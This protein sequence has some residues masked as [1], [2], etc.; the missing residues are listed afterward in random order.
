MIVNKHFALG[1]LVSCTARRTPDG[2]VIDFD[3]ENSAGV[4]TFL[5]ASTF[6]LEQP[7]AGGFFEDAFAKNP[8]QISFETTFND[9]F[10]KHIFS[11]QSIVCG[12][13]KIL[14]P[15]FDFVVRGQK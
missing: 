2:S 6:L 5:Q 13:K 1:T 10:D 15:G 12:E 7:W 4:K 9:Y 8:A 11:V 14:T 3:F